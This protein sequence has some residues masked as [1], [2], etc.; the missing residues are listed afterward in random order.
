MLTG[1]VFFF[2]IF[3]AIFVGSW[4][5]LLFFLVGYA[6]AGA[7]GVLAGGVTPVSMAFVLAAP[8]VPWVLWLFTAS[9][10]EAG[11]LRALLWPTLPSPRVASVGAAGKPL[12]S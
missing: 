4:W 11:L 7:S 2:L 10:P 3:A 9:V 5:L 1:F 6:V 8:T 12:P